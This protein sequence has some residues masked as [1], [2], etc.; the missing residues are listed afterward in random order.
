MIH[1]TA[2]LAWTPPR[3]SSNAS[4]SAGHA[5][6]RPPMHRSCLTCRPPRRDADSP[7]NSEACDLR[8]SPAFSMNAPLLRGDG[9]VHLVQ[10][11]ERHVVLGA[12][13]DL[14]EASPE[15]L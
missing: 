10:S 5:P 1:G 12:I 15:S 7:D 11:A 14:V 3:P 6:Y 9:R 13:V 4:C 8:S 2:A